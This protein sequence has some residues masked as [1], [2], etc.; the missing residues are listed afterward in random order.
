M[1]F[2]YLRKMQIKT[3]MREYFTFIRMTIIIK[4]QAT[5]TSEC[6]ARQVPS[7]VS[8]S[9]PMDCGPP[10]SSVHGI[11]QARTLES[12]C[13]APGDLP[14]P[15]I[16]PT[17]PGSPPL[18]ANSLPHLWGF[19]QKLGSSWCSLYQHCSNSSISF[20]FYLQL[21]VL[22][23]WK[24]FSNL[25]LFI[26]WLCYLNPKFLWFKLLKCFEYHIWKS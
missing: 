23:F 25:R 24:T 3:P 26:A 12:P 17:C 22:E 7:V 1:M 21:E 11:L 14:S 13:P 8:D 2:N 15:G 4:T 10:G 6:Y 5:S 19:V 18:H 9:S 20:P 16:E